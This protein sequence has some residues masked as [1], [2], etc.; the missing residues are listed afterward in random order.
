MLDKVSK[1]IEKFNMLQ[2]SERVLVGLSGGADSVSLLL[3]LIKLGYRVSAC[4]INH[5]LRGDESM[6]D[7]NFCIELCEKLD[8][9]IKVHRIDVK[10]YCTKNN[11]SVE[12]GARILRYEIFAQTSCDK[13]ATAHTLSDSLETT[14]F[15]LARGTGLKGLCS[16]P[17]TRENIVR[18]L[19]ECTRSD[20][21]AFLKSENQ[22]F[23]IDS[24]NLET[25]YSRNK[26]RHKVIPALEEINTSLLKTYM[27]TIENL[28]A[29]ESYLEAQTNELIESVQ[30]D[31]GYRAE[32]LN[33]AHPAIKNRAISEILLKENISVSHDRITD[34]AKI[35]E[36]SGKINLQTNIFAVC[37]N[38]YLKISRIDSK[39]SSANFCKQ[40]DFNE[41]YI[42][43]DK[44]VSFEICEI[45]DS[46]ENINKK[47]ANLYCDY[48]KIKGKV[49]L[50]SRKNGDKIK[51]CNRNFTASVK[52]LFNAS[53]PLDERDKI[54]ILEDEDGIIFIEG[55]G[56]ADRVKI[57]NHS[58][59]ILICKIS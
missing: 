25:D 47:V 52:K 31:K 15:N 39:I 38:G 56:C 4:H 28:K 24:T 13:I 16:V 40:V 10:D 36:S 21:E 22:D 12:E 58:A 26:I 19:I 46:F 27:K 42:F 32:Q 50:R 59:H 41:Q 53:V 3:C 48:D 43:F 34:I 37:K 33:K 49:S 23:V 44:T 20:I 14:I 17:P 8:I 11:C 29:D 2:K 5:Q 45:N 55:F 57:D 35:L 6:R 30:S 18:P 9:P 7:E 1:T 51:L 54:A